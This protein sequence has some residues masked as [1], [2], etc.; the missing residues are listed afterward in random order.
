[1]TNA[2]P[3]TPTASA[4]LGEV[5][6]AISGLLST[7]FDG[8]LTVVAAVAIVAAAMGLVL[9]QRSAAQAQEEVVADEAM[10]TLLLAS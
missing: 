6:A 4:G 9:R 10:D 3:A 7:S 2:R 5:P 1:M 8:T